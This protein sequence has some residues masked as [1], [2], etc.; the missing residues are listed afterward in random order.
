MG[1]I[2]AGIYETGQAYNILGALDMSPLR[3]EDDCVPSATII[4]SVGEVFS[5]Y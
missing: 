3:P 5:G 4:T 1:W 2:F